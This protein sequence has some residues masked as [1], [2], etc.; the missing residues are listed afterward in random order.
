MFR[1]SGG[2]FGVREAVMEEQYFRRLVHLHSFRGG[3]TVFKV[4]DNFARF[5]RE[6]KFLY[7][8][9]FCVPGGHETEY[10]TVLACICIYAVHAIY[11]LELGKI[12]SNRFESGESNGYFSIRCTLI[13]QSVH[14]SDIAMFGNWQPIS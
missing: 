10:S 7:H 1:E 14:S 6:K 3:A 13:T 9:T 2:A 11:M 8:L 12:D 4:G 5:A